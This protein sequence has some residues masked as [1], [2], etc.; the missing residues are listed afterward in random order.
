MSYLGMSG[1]GRKSS[2]HLMPRAI[3]QAK[4]EN[5]SASGGLEKC[6]GFSQARMTSKIRLLQNSSAIV[7]QNTFYMH[8]GPGKYI[9]CIYSWKW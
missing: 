7:S 1:S 6:S 9:L 3:S 4:E 2:F 5:L 8:F